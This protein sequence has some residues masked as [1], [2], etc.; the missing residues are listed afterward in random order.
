M[1]NNI[2]GRHRE[3]CYS[4]TSFET[5]QNSRKVMVR[6]RW[7]DLWIKQNSFAQLPRSIAV[8]RTTAVGVLPRKFNRA[9]SFMAKS[10]VL[11]VMV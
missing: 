8:L 2:T 7:Q 6:I 11:Y 9:Y 10:P 3:K 5:L 1:V 4:V